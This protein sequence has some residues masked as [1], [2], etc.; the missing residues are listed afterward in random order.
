MSAGR[1]IRPP[2]SAIPAPAAVTTGQRLQCSSLD[3]PPWPA[4]AWPPF[5]IA[6]PPFAAAT[7]RYVT[8]VAETTGTPAEKLNSGGGDGRPHSREEPPHGAWLACGPRLALQSSSANVMTCDAP[9]G[10]PTLQ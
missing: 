5:A 2:H 1:P 3:S 9:H 7:G 6:C 10:K 4:Y 8:P